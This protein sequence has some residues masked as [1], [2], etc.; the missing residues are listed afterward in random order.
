[1]GSVKVGGAQTWETIKDTSSQ[2]LKTDLQNSNFQDWGP[3]IY[4]LMNSPGDFL[5][6]RAVFWGAIATLKQEGEH[7]NRSLETRRQKF[8]SKLSKT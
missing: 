6:I 2:I 3:G 8:S 7:Q 4:I 5:A 1:M